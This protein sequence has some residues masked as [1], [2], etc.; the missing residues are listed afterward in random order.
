MDRAPY[1]WSGDMSDLTTLMDQVFAVRMAGD[2]P[3]RS[4]H[5]SL[6][7]FLQR[8]SPPA[9]PPAVDQDAVDRGKAL[10]E[11]AEVGCLGCHN[12][13]LMSNKQLVDVGTGGKF[14]VPSLIGVGARPPYIH[15]GCARTLTDRFGPCG[16]G[17]LHGH[18]SQLTQAQIADLVA[19]LETL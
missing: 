6:G 7:P 5:M 17:D 9:P 16:G 13:T 3:T 8:I 11:S 18:T 14:K 15:D 19:Y 1:H 4:Q 12:G 2:P 10:F